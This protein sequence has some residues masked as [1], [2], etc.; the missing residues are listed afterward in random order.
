MDTF[1]EDPNAT[2]KFEAGSVHTVRPGDTLW[3]VSRNTLEAQGVANPT[4]AQIAQGVKLI[5]ETSRANRS[6]R[7]QFPEVDI[8][9]AHRIGRDPDLIHAGEQV[10]IPDMSKV[11]YP[12]KTFKW[13]P[14]RNRLVEV[15][16]AAEEQKPQLAQDRVREDK[17]F[18]E[19]SVQGYLNAT[20][21]AAYLQSHPS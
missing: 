18:A 3:G 16:P 21:A 9:S 10:L 6:K 20:Q 17:T 15:N 12:G 5:S 2:R 19:L 4:D 8:H 14:T 1:R 11:I 13:D 7:E